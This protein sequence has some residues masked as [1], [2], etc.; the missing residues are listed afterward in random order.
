[1]ADIVAYNQSD[2]EQRAFLAAVRAGEGGDNYWI[3]F[4]GKDLSK[5]ARDQYGFPQWGGAV[6][7][8]GPTHAAGAYQ[9]QPGT[10]REVASKYGLNFSNPFDQD[11]G[12]WYNAQRKYAANT[13]GASLDADLDAG[14]FEKVRSALKQEWTSLRDNPQKFLSTIASG[15]GAEMQPGA[16]DTSGTP[17]FFSSPVQAA[18]AYFVRGGMIL[19]GTVIL[20]VAL[21]AL[22]SR[23]D[24]AMGK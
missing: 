1:M 18:G 24:F 12:A 19:V 13:G 3:G 2:A 7:G 8:E 9:F 10:W 14:L 16:T 23:T 21:W 22:L 11:S 4:G 5:S 20:L 15:A 6:T 17:S